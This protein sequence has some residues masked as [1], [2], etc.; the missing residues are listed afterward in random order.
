M[1]AQVQKIT[2]INVYVRSVSELCSWLY[3]AR[4]CQ[5]GEKVFLL[6]KNLQNAYERMKQ[7][8]RQTARK[9]KVL[10]LCVPAISFVMLLLFMLCTF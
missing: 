5:T 10:L 8:D 2:I 6:M 4:F 1:L 9:S 7:M 3:S